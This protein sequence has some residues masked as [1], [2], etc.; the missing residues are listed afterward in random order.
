MFLDDKFGIAISNTEISI[1]T[2]AGASWLKQSPRSQC[3]SGLDIKDR[4]TFAVG[5][6]CI[7]LFKSTNGGKTFAEDH[8]MRAPF[9]I[10]MISASSVIMSDRWNIVQT[11][12]ID[13]PI[14]HCALKA[15]CAVSGSLYTAVSK[16]SKCI[17][18]TDAGETWSERVI[19]VDGSSPVFNE[20][21]VCIRFIDENNGVIVYY[22]A[23]GKQKGWFILATADGG[24]T[25]SQDNIT[26][27]ISQTGRPL[28][29]QD[30]KIL[31]IVPVFGQGDITIVKRSETK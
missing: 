4:N 25:W 22:S 21:T 14:A 18:S 6:G 2:D 12:Q 19:S 10:S 17:I 27:Y 1:T 7:G 9:L 20:Q 31:T 11:K 8:Q 24:K 28:V 26:P 29:S 16:D 5:T 3:F 23:E 30:G 15:F 13:A